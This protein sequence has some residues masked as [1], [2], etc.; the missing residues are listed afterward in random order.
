MADINKV[1]KELWQKT[2]RN[3]DIDYIAIRWGEEGGA[4]ARCA[5]MHVFVRAYVGRGGCC[6][7]VLLCGCR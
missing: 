3:S 4:C 6:T 5:C 1:I 7:P 2:Y